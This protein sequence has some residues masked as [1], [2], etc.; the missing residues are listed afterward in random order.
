MF[1][2]TPKKSDGFGSQFQGIIFGI[3]FSEL[4]GYK[5]VY[6]K[7]E[8]MEHNYE[9]DLFF[10]DKIE[11][12]MNIQNNYLHYEDICPD[13]VILLP[14]DIT[15][16]YVEQNLDFCLES[17]SMKQI[18]QY[19]WE[20]KDKNVFH[21]DKINVAVHIR[22]PNQHDNRIEGANTPDVYY[23]KIINNIKEEHKHKDLCFHIFSQGSI[24]NFSNFTK[25]ENVVFHLNEDIEKTFIMLV[26]ADILVT[27]ASSLSY[28][29][30]LLSE[31][32]VYFLPFWHPPSKKWIV[33]D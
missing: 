16:Y 32:T 29:A 8:S 24:E 21:N 4:N 15:Y 17:Q 23:L 12:L 5:Y 30:A 7:I 3:L 27:S 13:Q 28:V 25:I 6:Q 26:A 1:I 11:K 2:T 33:C 31:N 10:L 22:R 18:K 9:N 14:Q 19:F 20:N